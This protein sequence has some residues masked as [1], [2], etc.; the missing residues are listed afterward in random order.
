[1][2]L[3]KVRQTVA[4]FNMLEKGDSVLVGVS[5]GPDSIA[6]LYCLS[7]L[8]KEFGLDLYVA[9]LNHM[10]RGASAK[11]DAM[12]VEDTAQRF[13][14][15][16]IIESRNVPNLARACGFSIEEAARNARYDFYLSAASRSNAKKIAL[17]HTA[18]DQTETVLMRLLRGS[19]LLGLGGIPPVRRLENRVIIRPLIESYRKEIM[20][21]LSKNHI[22][23]REDPT[24]SKPVYLRNKIRRKLIPFIEREFNLE[25]RRIL[26]ETA[27]N[28]R[29]DYEYLLAVAQRKMKKYARY[30]KTGARINISFLKEPPALR[31]MIVREA[32]RKVKGDLNSV[33]YRHWESLSGLLI[34]K[35]AWSLNLP[36]VVVK[37][38]KNNLIFCRPGADK[39]TTVSLKGPYQLMVPGK[40]ELQG[41]GSAIEARFIKNP[42]R[43]KYKKSKSE[44][45]FDF[46]KLKPPFYL[47]FR[48]TGDRIMPLG[49]ERYKRLKQL[50]IDEKIPVSRR[51]NIPILFSRDKL[52]WVCGV[53]RSGHAKIDARTKTALML[54]ITKKRRR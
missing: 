49:M 44:E 30:S 9:H 22:T 26:N 25:I 41:F 18:D 1:M 42:S 39:K 46:K 38:E 10:I 27:K 11:K 37:K 23:Y 24:N 19:G 31:R 54:K 48:K 53:K 5:G 28:L 16:V 52:L 29:T 7:A 3:E 6:L 2:L 35:S 4:R 17:G 32:V 47:R 51:D 34:G 36:G 15:P 12:F 14:L 45:Y 40:T 8:K 33:T 21:F 50:F 43:L 13:K 20:D